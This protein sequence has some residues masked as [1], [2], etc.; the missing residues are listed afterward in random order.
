MEKTKY[1][2]ISCLSKRTMAILLSGTLIFVPGCK[3]QYKNKYVAENKLPDEEYLKT[4]FEN[5]YDCVYQN[6]K[7]VIKYYSK[8]I[9][10][11]YDPEVGTKRIY[12]YYEGEDGKYLYTLPDGKLEMIYYLS[13][14]NFHYWDPNYDQY[15][16][17]HS[18]K[19]SN[20]ELLKYNDAIEE[21]K[22]SYEIEE[23]NNLLDLYAIGVDAINET[24][25]EGRKK[26]KQ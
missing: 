22:D 7:G 2:K 17:E 5:T 21:I 20:D 15:I 26:V 4:S 16:K 18:V 14:F 3:S 6:G 13:D 23:L 1:F 25:A 10:L 11:F 19:L 9:R 24:R 8:Y 12:Y